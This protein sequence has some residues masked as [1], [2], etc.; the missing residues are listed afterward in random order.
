MQHI[1]QNIIAFIKSKPPE[2]FQFKK[3]YGRTTGYFKGDH[4]ELDF[5][6]DL[7]QSIIHECTHAL[8][9]ELS[10]TKVLKIERAILKIITNLEVAEILAILAKKIKHTETR[11][12]YLK[13]E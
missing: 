10:E 11:Q 6:K 1:I 12:S 2:F 5:R 8:Y 4:I 7:V 3:I 13:R 9:P